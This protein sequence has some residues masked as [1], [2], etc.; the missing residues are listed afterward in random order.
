MFL[1]VFEKKWWKLPKKSLSGE[2]LIMKEIDEKENEHGQLKEDDAAWEPDTATEYAATGSFPEYGSVDGKDSDEASA[3][4]DDEMEEEY[5]EDV[6]SNISDEDPSGLPED[7]LSEAYELTTSE[8]EEEEVTKVNTKINTPKE[9]FQTELVYRYDVLEPSEKE[10]IKG[11][12]RI[13]IR[14][15][16]GGVWTLTFDNEVSVSPQKEDAE[17]VLMMHADDFV[18]VVNGKVNPQLAL[19]SRRIKISGNSKRASLF[20]NILAPRAE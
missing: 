8:L 4:E 18:S 12:Y 16:E 20:Q 5:P 7:P 6:F 17:L 14:G 10:E 2:D 9:F 1:A 11:T 3:L 15:A 13:E 19:A